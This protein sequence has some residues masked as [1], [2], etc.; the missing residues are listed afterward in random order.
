M[1]RSAELFSTVGLILD[2]FGVVLLF[3]FGLPPDVSR[4]GTVRL[5]LGADEREARKGKRYERLSWAALG[6]IITGFTLQ[7][8]GTWVG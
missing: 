3:R 7:I 4:D 6:L 5:V 8:V 2:I 1:S